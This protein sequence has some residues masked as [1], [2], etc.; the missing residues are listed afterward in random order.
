MNP[1]LLVNWHLLHVRFRTLMWLV[2]IVLAISVALSAVPSAH[3]PQAAQPRQAAPGG[4][5]V[6][7]TPRA[8]SVRP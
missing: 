3:D 1:L 7:V 2:A 6:Q 5:A 8:V 4:A